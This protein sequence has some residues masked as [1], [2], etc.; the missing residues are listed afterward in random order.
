MKT[1][2]DLGSAKLLAPETE[3]IRAAADAL[4]FCEDVGED[5]VAQ[6]AIADITDLRRHLVESD[7]WLEETA[8]RL[9]ADVLA[10]GPLEPVH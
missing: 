10:C 2:E 9:L 6:A 1:V 3:R 4:F 8:E 5:E 7:R